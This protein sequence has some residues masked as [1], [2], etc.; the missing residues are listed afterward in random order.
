MTIDLAR[1]FEASKGLF[2]AYLTAWILASVVWA[3][4]AGAVPSFAQQTGQPCSACHVGSF[5]PQLKP[6]GRD[7]KLNGYMSGDNKSR[8]LPLAAM[9]MASLTHTDADQSPPPDPHFGG[10]NNVALDQVSVFY[11]G[12]APLGFGVFAQ[13]TYSQVGNAFNLDNFDIRRAQQVELFGKDTLVAIDVNNNPTVEDP[14]NTTP[15][16]GFPYS[17]SSLAPGA[18]AATLLDGG[19]EH[20]VVGS[21]AYIFWN[22]TVYLDAAVYAPLARNVAGWL[23]EG[24]DNTSDRYRGVIP[25]GRVAFVHDLDQAQTQTWEVGA[26][27]FRARRNPGGDES[28]G[29]DAFSD[30]AVDATYQYIGD[31]RHVVSAHATYIHENQDLRAS[32]AL[33]GTNPRNTLSTFRADVSYSYENTWTP[34]F[35]AFRTTG[36]SDPTFYGNGVKTSGYVFEL[37]Y[38]PFGKAESPVSWANARVGLQYVAYTEFNG[39]RRGASDNNTLYLNFWV[40]LAPLG[41]LV[42]R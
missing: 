26:Y 10:N 5:G 27:G 31:A 11:A 7:F 15:A 22:N 1:A 28:Q 40:A 32:A 36:S 33:F 16:W 12:R 4:P 8:E 3:S 35:Q 25:Y 39:Q 42:H 20:L 6:Y 14:W 34:S 9:V 29:A 23:G 19:L 37:A 13:G 18:A 17:G 2:A 38:S 21:G 24:V 41:Y 30:W